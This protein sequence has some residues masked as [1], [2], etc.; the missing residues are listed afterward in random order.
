MFTPARL[1]GIERLKVGI[2]AAGHFVR[3]HQSPIRQPWAL[4]PAPK[5]VNH[6]SLFTSGAPSRKARSRANSTEGLLIL[7]HSRK[8]C[9]LAVRSKPAQDFSIASSTSRPPTCAIMR[10][11]DRTPARLRS[12]ANRSEE[13]RVG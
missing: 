10:V 8:T 9:R 2:F 6:Q 12:P 13:R 1:H 11:M 7:P 5:L 4:K 3:H